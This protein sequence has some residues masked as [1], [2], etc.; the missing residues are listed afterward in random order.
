MTPLWE[1]TEEM[2]KLSSSDTDPLGDYADDEDF[3]DFT[4]EHPDCESRPVEKLAVVL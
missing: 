4:A 2:R 3:A 1:T